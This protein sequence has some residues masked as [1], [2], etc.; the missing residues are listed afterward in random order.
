MKLQ[1]IT[2]MYYKE[3][4][5]IPAYHWWDKIRWQIVKRLGGANP[6]ET[7][8]VKRIFIDADKFMEKLFKQRTALLEHFNLEAEELLIGADDFEELMNEEN[9]K[10]SFSFYAS[11]NHGR[12]EIY[13]L[14]ITVIPWMKGI[15]VMPK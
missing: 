12:R 1:V 10:Q 5:F 9:I 4:P 8:K 14:K 15:L 11:Y 3:I 2:F 7:V 13:G 6:L